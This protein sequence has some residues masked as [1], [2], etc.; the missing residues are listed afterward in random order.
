ML[1]DQM[2]DVLGELLPHHRERALFLDHTVR[3]EQL[4]DLATQR[5]DLVVA[6]RLQPRTQPGDH[7]DDGVVFTGQLID[8][9]YVLTAAV[10]TE[11]S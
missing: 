9:G 5:D 1:V 8:R 7:S 3:R 11:S 6:S 2:L 4:E 10:L